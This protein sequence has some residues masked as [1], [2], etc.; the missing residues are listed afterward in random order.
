MGSVQHFLQHPNLLLV[1]NQKPKERKDSFYHIVPAHHG[2]KEFTLEQQK[3]QIL[4][5]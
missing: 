2:I 3:N 1:F 4:K 5:K